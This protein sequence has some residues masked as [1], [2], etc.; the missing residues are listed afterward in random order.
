MDI[1]GMKRLFV[2]LLCLALALGGIGAM[3]EPLKKGAKGDAVTALQVKLIEHNYQTVAA[4]GSYGNK[5]VK[6]VKQ[7]QADAGLEQTGIADDATLTYLEGHYAT[8]EPKKDADV[9]LYT[10]H[11]DPIT[12][13]LQVHIKNMG[14]QRIV[15]YTFK[16]YQCNKSKSSLGSFYGEKNKTTT[17]KKKHTKTRHTNWTEHTIG[18]FVASGDT[19]TGM[20]PLAEGTTV[21]FSDGSMQ[22]VTYFEKGEL[23]R[24]VLSSYTTEDGKKHKVNQKLHCSFR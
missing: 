13:I 20:L 3:A 10:I 19:A 5:T 21:M 17:N 7:V 11:C 6:A 12:H 1:M 18:A 22:A 2:C 16:L 9:L 24:V 15:S 8:F 23:A 14:R 4:D